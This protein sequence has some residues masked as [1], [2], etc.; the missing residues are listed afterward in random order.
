MHSQRGTDLARKRID[1]AKFAT[2]LR[3]SPISTQLGSFSSFQQF[4]ND[5]V[6]TAKIDSNGYVENIY[7]DHHIQYISKRMGRTIPHPS[8]SLLQ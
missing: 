8:A 1:S 4:L 2:K 3:K 7:F 5:I 6:L